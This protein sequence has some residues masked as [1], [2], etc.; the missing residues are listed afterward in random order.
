[1][2]MIGTPTETKEDLEMTYQLIRDSHPAFVNISRTTPVPGSNMYDYVLK[3]GISNI[4]DFWE[5]DYYHNEYPIRL[6]NLTREDLKIYYKKVMNIWLKSFI[7]YPS[8]AIEFLKLVRCFPSYGLFFIKYIVKGLR[9]GT[10]GK[11]FAPIFALQK[12]FRLLR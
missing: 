9:T 2:I 10:T 12:R 3:R 5:F 8:F 4:N 1:Y 6:E 11:F 7:T